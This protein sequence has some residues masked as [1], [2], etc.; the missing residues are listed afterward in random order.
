MIKH[1]TFKNLDDLCDFLNENKID[2]Y[3]VDS[4]MGWFFLVYGYSDNNKN[5]LCPECAK[6]HKAKGHRL[7]LVRSEKER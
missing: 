3:N 5:D 1:K 4:Y 6:K 2:N 7:H